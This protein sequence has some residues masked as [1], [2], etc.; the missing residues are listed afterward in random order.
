MQSR[1]DASPSD[2]AGDEDAMEI[3]DEVQAQ[4]K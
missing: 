1:Q 2:N 4:Q 3:G